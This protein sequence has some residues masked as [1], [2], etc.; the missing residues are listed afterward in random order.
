MTNPMWPNVGVNFMSVTD[1]VEC[2][3]KTYYNGV[4]LS[5][6][7]VGITPGVAEKLARQEMRKKIGKRRSFD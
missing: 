4:D 5:V 1:G 7:V 6:S 2:T 3:M